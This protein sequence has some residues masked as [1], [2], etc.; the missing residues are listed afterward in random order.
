MDYSQLGFSTGMGSHSLLQGIFLTQGSD[1]S[2]LPCRQIL[3]HQSH[4]GSPHESYLP[5]MDVFSKTH[6][7]E[8]RSFTQD[9]LC[10]L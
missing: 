7:I 1:P 9:E 4:Q 3:Y 2:L 8:P 5:K 10:N 6:L